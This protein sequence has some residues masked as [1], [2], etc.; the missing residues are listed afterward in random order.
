MK[1]LLFALILTPGFLFAQVKEISHAE[2]IETYKD[3]AISEMKRTGIP[4]SIT[5]AQGILESGVGNSEL[6]KK[7]KNH[8]GIKCHSNWEGKT[9]IMDDD[10]EDE[11]FRVYKNAKQSYVD[12]S[13]FLTV[14]G[15]YSFLFDLKTTDYKG[16]AQGLKKAGYATNP[17]YP[18]LLVGIIE[19]YNLDQYDAYAK[20]RFETSDYAN[21]INFN[22]SKIVYGKEGD[23]Y[24]SIGQKYDISLKRILK[25]NDLT[26]DQAVKPSTRVFLQPKR[27]RAKDRFHIV[28]HGETMLD[29]S[30][31]H[32]VKLKLLYKRNLMA[33]GKEPKQGEKLHLNRKRKTEVVSSPKTDKYGIRGKKYTVKRGDTLYSIAKSFDVSVQDIKDSND[34]KSNDLNPGDTLIIIRK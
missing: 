21:A 1:Q 10:T 3:I 23:T 26:K 13:S 17:K 19:R 31:Q 7:A 33:P 6:A 24:S 11:C 8:F 12:H 15:R 25:Y 28:K 9:F 14:R 27:S 4:A 20:R 22:N 34:L 18:Q 5:L 16:W 30:N 32:G 29:I 2:Y